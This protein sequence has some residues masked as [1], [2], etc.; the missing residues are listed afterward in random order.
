MSS[1]SPC[2]FPGD[3]WHRTNT[4]LPSAG[5]SSLP[6]ACTSLGPFL[7]ANPLRS[8]RSSR[9]SSLHEPLGISSAS[10][11]SLYL[12]AGQRPGAA[13]PLVHRQPQLPAA[14]VSRD[15]GQHVRSAAPAPRGNL[16]RGVPGLR[17]PLCLSER[18]D[19]ASRLPGRSY[20]DPAASRSRLTQP[21]SAQARG[22]PPPVRW[23]G[24]KRKGPE[25]EVRC[26]CVCLSAG[27]DGVRGAERAG[28]ALHRARR[29]GRRRRAVPSRPA[30]PSAGLP[31]GWGLG[32]A[33]PCLRPAV[34]L[35]CEAPGWLP[36][37]SVCGGDGLAGSA[38]VREF[39]TFWGG[40]R[41][42]GSCPLPGARGRS[43]G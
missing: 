5:V 37:S 10:F 22:P 34:A 23:G 21:G 16:L 4:A 13:R 28:E 17:A 42:G 2:S 39:W 31:A 3:I 6:R 12:G 8:L 9:G 35:S 38:G 41:A 7:E 14:G 43:L 11:R 15:A 20:G 19:A 29:A 40:G 26:E 25:A 32:S 30:P 27:S 18:G 33:R 24:R 1:E 36:A